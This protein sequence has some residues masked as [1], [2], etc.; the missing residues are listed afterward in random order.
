MKLLSWLQRK[1]PKPVAEPA[2]QERYLSYQCAAVQEIGTRERQ[3]DAWTLINAED[4]TRIRNEGLLAVVADGM[5]G[6]EHGAFASQMSIQIIS[7]D[8]RDMDRTE[9]LEQQLAQSVLHAADGVYSRLQGAGGSTVIA[10]MVFEQQLYYAGMGDSY[11]YLLRQGKLIRLNREQNVLHK[12]Y[13]ELIRQGNMDIS[14]IAG[15]AQPHAV[16]DFLGIDRT[17][18]LDW[19]CRAMPLMDDDV[20]LL[21]SDGVGGVL[22]PSEICECIRIP[23]ANAAAA[24][25]QN[26]ILS[27]GYANQDNY[28]AVIIRCK[29]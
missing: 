19:L 22:L 12:R 1:S 11:L 26:K 23:D 4:V 6:L 17:G 2:T 15:I 28:T 9:P 18:E 24:A 25:L 8:F 21:C 27:K 3:E 16:T 14:M 7:E 29:K 10:C 20:L 5:G 13:L